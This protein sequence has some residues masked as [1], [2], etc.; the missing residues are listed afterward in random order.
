[1]KA[2]FVA[3]YNTK[4]KHELRLSL[5]TLSVR[6]DLR[7]MAPFS[8]GVCRV[9]PRTSPAK[10]P[11]SHARHKAIVTGPGPHAFGLTH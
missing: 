4:V 11:E 3:R 9:G 10:L 7:R 8:D 6:W 1:M 5:I 2:T